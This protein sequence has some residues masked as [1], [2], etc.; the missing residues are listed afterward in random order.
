MK[1]GGGGEEEM[2]NNIVMQRHVSSGHP[3]LSYHSQKFHSIWNRKLQ[4]Q[5][6]PRKIKQSWAIPEPKTR[7]KGW[8]YITYSE[9]SV[10]QIKINKG[11]SLPL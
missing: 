1:G 4:G 7:S 10:K 5:S 6:I 9:H 3:A 11:A 8:S 2:F